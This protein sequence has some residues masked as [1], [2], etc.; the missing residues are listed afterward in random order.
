[1]SCGNKSC[2]SYGTYEKTILYIENKF[3]ID[4]K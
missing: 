2:N 1:M 4:F 3:I